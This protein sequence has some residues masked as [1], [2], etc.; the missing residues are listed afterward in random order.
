VIKKSVFHVLEVKAAI[1]KNKKEL[2]GCS[3]SGKYSKLFIHKRMKGC[4]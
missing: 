3:F 4:G 1:D 2:R